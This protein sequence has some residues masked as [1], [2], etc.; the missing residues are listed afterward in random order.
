MN[1][2][3]NKYTR[4]LSLSSQKEGITKLMSYLMFTSARTRSSR[5]SMARYM[6]RS[7]EDLYCNTQRDGEAWALLFWMRSVFHGLPRKPYYCIKYIR[8]NKILFESFIGGFVWK[9]PCGYSTWNTWCCFGC[10]AMPFQN[11][12][13]TAE[14]FIMTFRAIQI[15]ADEPII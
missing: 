12:L 14:L 9:P 10:S 7:H 6:C 8:T 3:W 2:V 5:G 15:L 1:L 13:K 4:K 11:S